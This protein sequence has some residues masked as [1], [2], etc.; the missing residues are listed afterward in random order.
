MMEHFVQSG[1]FALIEMR[2]DIEQ[3]RSYWFKTEKQNKTDA[4]N[5]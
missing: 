1:S 5:V 4:L 3:K 2:E